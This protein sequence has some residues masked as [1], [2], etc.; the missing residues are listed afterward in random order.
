V[1]HRDAVAAG[2]GQA[3]PGVPA[4]RA[5]LRVGEPHRGLASNPP[6]PGR[7]RP[8]LCSR[9]CLRRG[10]VRATTAAPAT[11]RCWVSE[12]TARSATSRPRGPGR[13]RGQ[14]C[15]SSGFCAADK[16]FGDCAHEG[17]TD[18]VRLPSA[19]PQR[20]GGSHGPAPALQ[21]GHHWRRAD[22][23]SKA[24]H[25]CPSPLAPAAGRRPSSCSGCGRGPRRWMSTDLREITRPAPERPLRIQVNCTYRST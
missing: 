8:G 19:H 11:S 21:S 10:P 2:L 7:T 5:I 3:G 23:S 6:T 1:P 16:L 25:R 22:S 13:R 15:W 12:S 9:T 18:I 4:A 17:R 14:T 20:A 24:L